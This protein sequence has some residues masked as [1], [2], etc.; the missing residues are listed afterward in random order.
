MLMLMLL[1]LLSSKCLSVA[2]IIVALPG[3]Q[4]S[5]KGV[6]AI[7][8]IQTT[9]NVTYNNDKKMIK[10]LDK[11]NQK[12]KTQNKIVVLTHCFWVSN[13]L[14]RIP[15]ACGFLFSEIKCSNK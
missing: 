5:D 15:T 1:L 2:V 11:K 4:F 10:F 9:T 14:Q 6:F 13:N 7:H 3:G 8:D 12:P